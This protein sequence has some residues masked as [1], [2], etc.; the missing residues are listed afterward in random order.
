MIAVNI[1]SMQEMDPPVIAEYF[2]LLRGN[3]AARM[4]FYCCNKLYKRLGDGTELKFDDYPWRD[5]DQ[6]LHD[7]VCSWSQWYYDMKPPFWH[8]RTG[9]DRVIWHRL[10][11]LEMEDA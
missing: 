11:L 5:G 3:K 9:K 1:V 7:S 8:H 2:R 6:V 10:A 4:A